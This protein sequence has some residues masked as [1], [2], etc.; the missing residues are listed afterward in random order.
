L[1][2]V[3]PE[4]RFGLRDLLDLREELGEPLGRPIDF[5]FGGEMRSWLHDW[6]EGDRIGIF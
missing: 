3:D 2:E 6:I 1:I 5:A 4:A